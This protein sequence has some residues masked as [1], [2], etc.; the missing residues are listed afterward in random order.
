MDTTKLPK[1]VSI[2]NAVFICEN[3]KSGQ[4]RRWLTVGLFLVVLS[5]VIPVLSV[6]FGILSPA[7]VVKARAGVIGFLNSDLLMLPI[8]MCKQAI[9]LSVVGGGLLGVILKIANFRRWKPNAMHYS[10]CVRWGSSLVPESIVNPQNYVRQYPGTDK[11]ILDETAYLA[12]VNNEYEAWWEMYNY[13]QSNP[14]AKKPD[15][16]ELE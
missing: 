12:A 5:Y 2:K 14:K 11:R 1:P 3:I 10:D 6:W 9:V 13:Q 7:T 8:A 16:N 15:E 4:W